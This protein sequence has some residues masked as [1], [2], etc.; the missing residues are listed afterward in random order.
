MALKVAVDSMPIS[1]SAIRVKGFSARRQ[2]Q[3]FTLLEVV[4]VFFLMAVLSAVLMTAALRNVRDGALPGARNSLDATLQLM[5]ERSLF[6][7]ELLALHLEPQRITPLRLNPETLAFEPLPEP[8]KPLLL[9]E[10]LVLEWQQQQVA[11]RRD[12]EL[13]LQQA[14]EAFAEAS[15]VDEP[16]RPQ[17]FFFPSGEVSATHFTLRDIEADA[18]LELQLSSLGKVRRDPDAL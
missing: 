18:M 1:I 13:S 10:P 15:G 2:Q 16:L 8:F 14:G 9:E 3:G 4:L 6:N 17:V 11:R 12:N 5:A 7:G